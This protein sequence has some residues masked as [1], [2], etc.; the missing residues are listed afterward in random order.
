VVRDLGF[1]RA[2]GRKMNMRKLLVLLTLLASLTIAQRASAQQYVQS[3]TLTSANSTT[4]AL[5]TMVQNSN[6]QSH[7]LTWTATPGTGSISTCT[8]Q[9][10]TAPDNATW[11]NVGAAQTCTSSG[12]YSLTGT[13][14]IYVRLN[15]TSPSMTGNATIQINYFGYTNQIGASDNSFFIY[16]PSACIG[17]TTGTAG[18]G[19]ASVVLSGGAVVY[20]VSAT[21][22]SSSANTF[23]CTFQLPNRTTAGKSYTITDIAALV[24]LQTTLPTSITLPT[25]KTFVAPV[26]AAVE[27]LNSATFVTTGGTVSIVPTSAQIAAG[28]VSAVGA[29]GQ[30]FTIDSILGTPFT[31]TADYTT[32]Q[33]VVLFNQSA[34]AI[35]IQEL[36]GFNVHYIANAL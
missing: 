12:S 11:T 10:Q 33:F 29:A 2:V 1:K 6:V 25:V 20:R 32:F 35:S 26:A 34:S 8:V 21:A 24:S 28:T 36:L 3:I 16:A 5:G 27:T 15:I 30:F 18:A 23:T 9:L 31:P 14:A 13:S 17:S 7:V 19:N 4:L 22:A